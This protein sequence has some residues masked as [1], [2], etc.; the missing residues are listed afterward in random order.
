MQRNNFM[1][2]DGFIW[3]MGVV[4][5]R[6]DPL[7]MGRVQIRAFGWH[8]E[9]KVSIPTADLPWAQPLFASNASI[10]T[11]T[12]KEGDYV[13]GFF[14]DGDGA[15][16]PVYLG[17][18]PGIPDQDANQSKGFAD[19]RTTDELQNTP[20]KP[21]KNNIVGVNGVS[22]STQDKT[23]YPRTKNE[24][25]T[26]KLSRNESLANT[27]I[28][29]RRRN[30][31]NVNS[32]N[33]TTWREPYPGYNTLYPYSSTTE[34][35]S[36]HIFQ[37]DDTPGNERVML[38]HRTGTTYEVYN[39][40]TKLEKIVKDNYTIVHGSDMCYVN[41]KL[42]LT[43]ENVA[44]IRIKGKTTIEIDG[45]V[46]FKVAGDMNLS[47]GKALNIKAASMT[48]E[49]AGNDSH[50]VGSKN[51]T[52]SGDTQIRY[53][54]D[55]HTHIGADTYNKHDGGTDYSCPSDP[56]RSG[57]TDC[58]SVDSATV[59]GLSNPNDYRSPAEV[60]PVPEFINPNSNVSAKVKDTQPFGSFSPEQSSISGDPA[61]ASALLNQPDTDCVIGRLTQSEV[62]AYFA[63]IAKTESGGRY[64][65]VNSIGFIGKYQFGW[66]AL[67]DSGLVKRVKQ[68]SDLQNS[69]NWN[70]DLSLEKFLNGHDLQE[71]TMCQYT[72][73]N[74]R[75][76]VSLGVITSSSDSATV[77]G[78]LA[79]SHLLGPGGAKKLSL[80]QDGSDAYGTTGTKYYLNGRN[81]VLALNSSSTKTT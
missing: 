49:V 66:A 71:K 75:T 62:K 67:F 56:T 38:S 16:M 61:D 58:A 76:L 69:S 12:P 8:T 18:L 39:S 3:F 81:A 80:G 4:E 29:F 20:V 42:E 2:L 24:P 45:D 22:I 5:N 65:V 57:S 30:W 21:V 34:T 31:V 68:N 63:Q 74:Y 47:V 26:S 59:A 15:Q 11:N 52:I 14:T 27:I 40:G 10:T 54:G 78:Y 9:D 1:G 70:N 79:V 25:T 64:N 41:G 51:E 17:V 6:I 72:S 37:L 55:L 7:M 48:T 19:P 35:E 73:R 46:D 60:S 33:G 53:E 44:K 36:G 32:T 43:V 28:D 77:A 13:V 23:P 50:L